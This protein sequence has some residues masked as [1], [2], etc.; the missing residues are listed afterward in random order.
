MTTLYLHVTYGGIE[1]EPATESFT[2][3]N[4][5]GAC[6]F[7]LKQEQL[8]PAQASF[9]EIRTIPRNWERRTPSTAYIFFHQPDKWQSHFGCNITA[10][11]GLLAAL[12]V[13]YLAPAL[14]T[15]E[16][17]TRFDGAEPGRLPRAKEPASLLTCRSG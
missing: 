2:V 16:F 7:L 8:Q 4:S 11:S 15:E 1:P 9:R 3:F 14:G 17:G 12:G 6:L 5:P 10:P 13:P